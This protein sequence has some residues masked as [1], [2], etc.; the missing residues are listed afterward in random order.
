[1]N[2]YFPQCNLPNFGVRFNNDIGITFVQGDARQ[3]NC[4]LYNPNTAQPYD[5]T[6]ATIGINFQRD[7][8]GSIKRTNGPVNALSAQ[9]VIANGTVGIG[10]VEFPDHGFVTGD[11][12]QVASTGTLPAPLITATNYTIVTIDNDN[13]Y[14]AD[15]SGNIISLTSQGS[16]GFAITNSND[17][18]LGVTPTLGQFIFNLRSDVSLDAN[19]MLAQ[20]FQVNVVLSATPNLK[21]ILLVQDLLDIYA[22]PAP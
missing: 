20:T 16:G 6:G 19:P 3:F 4:V 7:G 2:Q 22:Q 17:I 10:F 12:V 9:V 5:L 11:P 18:Q 21:N 13:F 1:M 15:T 14:F 8:G